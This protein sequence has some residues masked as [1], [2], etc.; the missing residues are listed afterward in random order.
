MEDGLPFIITG[1][2]PAMWLRDSTWQ[3]KPFLRSQN[4][5]IADF[6]VK[7]SKTQVKLFLED[8]YANAF[9][10]EPNGNCWHR[11]FPDQSP[12]V[13]ERKFELDSW[14]ALLY[15]ARQINDKFHRTDHLDDTFHEA[16]EKMK[17]LAITEQNHDRDAYIFKRTN[18]FEHDYLSHNGKGAPIAYTGMVYSAFRPSDDACTYGYLIPSNLFFLNELKRS[19]SYVANSKVEH[20]ISSITSGIH[21][22]GIIDGKYAYE[23]DGLGNTLFMDDANVPSLLSLPYLGVVEETDS[24]YTATRN[25]VLSATNPYY[26]DG[27]YA[28][29]VGSPH[30]PKGHVWP[31]AIAV[32][33]LSTSDRQSQLTALGILEKTDAGTGSMHESFDVNNP[34][35][36][37]REWFSW[38]DMT[39]VDLVLESVDYRNN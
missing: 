3:V 19:S 5:E 2:I 12:W 15:L 29:G 14:A 35:V 36:F 6:L 11:D 1:D 24:I 33:A 34:N 22:H 20:L 17:S 27:K 4:P 37:T 23:V 25:Y 32:Q 28:Q 18:T 9:N 8:P 13:F 7:L 16:F 30:T 10:P 26:F 38:A 21:N 31:I 39:Y